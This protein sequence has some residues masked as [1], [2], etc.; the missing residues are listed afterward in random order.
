MWM[1]TSTVLQTNICFPRCQM[2]LR[3]MVSLWTG[4]FPGGPSGKELTCQC[5]RL[6]RRGFDP[7]VWKI[8]WRRKWQPTFV[9]LPGKSHGERNLAG[10]SLWGHR[11]GKRSVFI[12]IPKKGNAK[13]C[14]NFC[15]IALISHA[16]KKCSKFSKP[17]FNST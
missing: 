6:N 14:S 15:T 3:F 10:Y 5:M 2:W 16:S 8:P 17:G 13:E 7:W 9:F 1:H 12:P 11:V 4:G